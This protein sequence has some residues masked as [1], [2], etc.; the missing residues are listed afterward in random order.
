MLNPIPSRRHVRPALLVVPA[1]WIPF[2]FPLSSAWVAVPA[3]R[4]W[5]GRQ[6]KWDF[7]QKLLPRE[8]G[9][10]GRWDDYRYSCPSG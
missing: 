5:T 1:N 10:I 9:E 6:M 7:S 3:V 4:N 2:S 8:K